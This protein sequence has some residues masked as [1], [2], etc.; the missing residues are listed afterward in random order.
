[1][2]FGSRETGCEGG[3][4]RALFPVVLNP[5]LGKPELVMKQQEKGR[6][7]VQLLKCFATGKGL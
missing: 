4:G 6:K 1:M 7:T 2:K 5:A 3:R